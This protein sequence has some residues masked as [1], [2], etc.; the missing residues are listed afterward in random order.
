MSTQTKV[1]KY[2]KRGSMV[3]GYRYADPISFDPKYGWLVS[4]CFPGDCIAECSGSGS[5]DEPVEW[6]R[7]ALKFAEA[8]EPVRALA[9]RYLREFGAWDDLETASIETLADRILWTACCDIREQGEWLGLV[10]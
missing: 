4:G 6:W 2:P 3:A 5:V 1:A 8:L 9:E 10:H 7:K